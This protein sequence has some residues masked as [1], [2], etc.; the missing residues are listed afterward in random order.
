MSSLINNYSK[1]G[2]VILKN[3]LSKK[4]INS[5]LKMI[6]FNLNSFKKNKTKKFTINS[7]KNNNFTK[8]LMNFR[9]KEPKLFSYY[10]DLVQSNII[11]KKVTTN[12]KI[13]KN[14]S[15][16]LK[17]SIN[18]ISHSNVMVRMDGPEDSRNVYDWHQERSYYLINN[19]YGGIFVWIAL[20]D[21]DENI[22]PLKIIPGS[23]KYGFIKPIPD[24][25]KLGSLQ[26]RI[27]TNYIDK[28]KNKVISV[29]M[30]AGD[31]IFCNMNI[32]HRSG[33]NKSELFRLS[34]ISRFHD[35]NAN[36]FRSYS[37]PGNYNFHLYKILDIKNLNNNKKI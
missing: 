25:K 26:N 30:K 8:K 31:A 35:S 28:N 18:S 10:Y 27:P 1:D 33:I 34:L 11:L 4:D 29:K 3:I 20:V 23:H 9:K 7:W 32:F 22:G 19:K 37:D 2:Y 15:K 12:Q 21:M 24:K 14:I 36:D 13:L 5:V 6:S 17:I 16:L